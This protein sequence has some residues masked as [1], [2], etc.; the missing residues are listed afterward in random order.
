MLFYPSSGP[1]DCRMAYVINGVL[2][3]V[4]VKILHRFGFQAKSLG[5]NE[6]HGFCLEF[7][8]I[9]A[10]EATAWPLFPVPALMT[11]VNMRQFMGKRG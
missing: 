4:A 7:S 11:E 3:Q 9:T 8:G 1:Y 5:D 6:R 2:F 10:I